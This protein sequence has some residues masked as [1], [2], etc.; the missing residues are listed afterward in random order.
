MRALVIVFLIAIGLGA[1]ACHDITGPQRTPRAIYGIQVPLF[2]AGSDTIH[3]AFQS[4]SGCDSGVELDSHLTESGVRF[5]V[6]AAPRA[7]GPCT[8][9]PLPFTFSYIVN[10]HH[11][12]P[13]TV[14]FA[15]PDKT[16][17]VRVVAAP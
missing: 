15:Q 6:T 13:F 12:V 11:A 16:D 4:A 5:S 3:I 9:D 1:A 2:A 14:G 17:D 8:L 7:S 10:P